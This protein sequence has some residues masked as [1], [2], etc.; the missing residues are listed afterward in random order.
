MPV[1]GTL[2]PVVTPAAAPRPTQRGWGTALR[3][4]EQLGSLGEGRV[5]TSLGPHWA[6]VLWMRAAVRVSAGLR[7]K[8]GP[9][10]KDRGSGASSLLGNQECGARSNLRG[11]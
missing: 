3:V 11:P 8:Q 4:G 7:S 2:E 9:G 10:Q 6:G 1:C 5:E